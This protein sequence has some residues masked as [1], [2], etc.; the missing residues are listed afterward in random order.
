M[1]YDYHE[2]WYWNH[3]KKDHMQLNHCA[4]FSCENIDWFIMPLDIWGHWIWSLT[5]F[6][7]SW[8]CQA[9]LES[10]CSALRDITSIQSNPHLDL[11]KTESDWGLVW[12]ICISKLKIYCPSLWPACIQCC[13]L[14]KIRRTII[15]GSTHTW[16]A[17]TPSDLC[18]PPSFASSTLRCLS[19]MCCLHLGFLEPPW[20]NKCLFCAFHTHSLW[21]RCQ[22]PFTSIR[23]LLDLLQTSVQIG[24]KMVPITLMLYLYLYLHLFDPEL[25]RLPPLWTLSP[26]VSS[27]CICICNYICLFHC[28]Y[29]YICIC[30][31]TCI[32]ICMTHTSPA[33][34][35]LWTSPPGA[36]S[37]SS[38]RSPR[39]SLHCGGST[40]DYNVLLVL[41][42]CKQRKDFSLFKIAFIKAGYATAIWEESFCLWKSSISFNNNW[43]YQETFNNLLT[44]K[45]LRYICVCG[46]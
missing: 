4:C 26:G 31:C 14:V 32:C 41:S 46:L 18:K 22:T 39:K 34:S 27:I 1:K 25:L 42:M 11:S 5:L 43:V 40:Q 37:I 36:S 19:K 23:K 7:Q 8:H 29:I 35:I 16:S 15:A 9:L 45:F 24:S 30:I 13:S 17:S 10:G 2:P 33:P 6:V 21:H 20:L 12:K 38:L 44:F 28:I 3:V